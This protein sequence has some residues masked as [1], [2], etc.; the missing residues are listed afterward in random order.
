MDY[1][2]CLP[3]ILN[4]NG[5]ITTSR[6][7]LQPICGIPLINDAID[8]DVDTYVFIFADK[9]TRSGAKPSIAVVFSQNF[10]GP[11][12]FPYEAN[13]YGLSEP[14]YYWK[15]YIRMDT[16]LKEIDEKIS[17]TL[18]QRIYFY[19]KEYLDVHQ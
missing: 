12:L 15:K 5:F 8:V 9:R 4:G 19:M 14:I 1:S 2:H 18:A 17:T 7:D 13:I 3:N 16:M 10:D 11:V 6:V